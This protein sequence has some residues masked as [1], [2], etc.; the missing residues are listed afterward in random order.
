MKI[1]KPGREQRGWSKECVCTG[2]GNGGGGCRATLLIEKDDV[3][4][5]KS[6]HYDG[7]YEEYHTFICISCG[8]L[9][10]LKDVPFEVR[11][12]CGPR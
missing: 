8:V 1:I 4:L 5:T 11:K 3:C 6:S 2:N 10:D 12:L 9:T 7:S